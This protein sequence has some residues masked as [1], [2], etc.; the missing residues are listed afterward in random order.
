[1]YQINKNSSEEIAPALPFIFQASLAT[2][3]LLAFDWKKQMLCHFKKVMQ[4]MI[5]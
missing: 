5:L 3:K 4:Q 1:M 2:A